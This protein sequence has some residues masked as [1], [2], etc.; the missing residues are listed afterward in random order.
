VRGLSLTPLDFEPEEGLYRLRTVKNGPLVCVKVWY[1]PPPDPDNPGELL[2][3]SPRWQALWLGR[4]CEVGN[5]LAGYNRERIDQAEYDYLL[6]THRWAIEHNP[7]DPM[8]RPRD[9]IDFN[10]VTIK[11]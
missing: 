7:D 1:G 8:A 6:G 3:R 2:D 4:E 5:A 11:F 10:S 9:R